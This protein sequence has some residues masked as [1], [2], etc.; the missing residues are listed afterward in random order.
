[1]RNT[2]PVDGDLAVYSLRAR[3]Q[4]ARIDVTSHGGVGP[5]PLSPPGCRRPGRESRPVH[6]TVGVATDDADRRPTPPQSRDTVPW[7]CRLGLLAVPH[8]A[9]R[10]GEAT[11][12]VRRYVPSV[13]NRRPP[14]A[15]DTT[16][17]VLDGTAEFACPVANERNYIVRVDLPPPRT[18]PPPS[19]IGCRAGKSHG[20]ARI[21]YENRLPV[22]VSGE[23]PRPPP[24]AV[25]SSSIYVLAPLSVACAYVCTYTVTLLTNAYV[26]PRHRRENRKTA[27]DTNSTVF[28][29][30]TPVDTDCVIRQPQYGRPCKRYLTP[31]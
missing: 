19:G 28:L 9:H 1:M 21:M 13:R 7:H 16:D 20:S 27:R 15:Y 18:W 29:S 8:T 5:P 10:D 25:A 31:R 3:A 12:T 23:G 26:P 2:R 17:S 11:A 4:T 6:S 24:V 30:G 14:T 22:G